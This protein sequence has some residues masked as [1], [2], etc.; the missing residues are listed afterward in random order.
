MEPFDLE[1]F[2]EKTRRPPVSVL[3]YAGPDTAAGLALYG[4]RTIGGPSPGP[5][6]EDTGR[7]SLLSKGMLGDMVERKS[8]LWGRDY[9]QRSKKQ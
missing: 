6:A 8:I 3:R 5:Q 7:I 4:G 1:A 2:R 9:E